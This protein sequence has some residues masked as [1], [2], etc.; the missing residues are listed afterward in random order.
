MHILL[1]ITKQHNLEAISTKCKI[2]LD[3]GDLSAL[4]FWPDAENL[5]KGLGVR[6]I[7]PLDLITNED[8]Y[9]L[10]NKVTDI[11]RNWWRYLFP[12]REEPKIEGL[13][14]SELYPYEIELSLSGILFKVIAIQKAIKRI[15][16]E[17]VLFISENGTG[18]NPIFQHIREPLGLLNFLYNYPISRLFKNNQEEYKNITLEDIKIDGNPVNKKQVRLDIVNRI[19]KLRKYIYYGEYNRLQKYFKRLLKKT[20]KF[21]DKVDNETIVISGGDRC[22]GGFIGEAAKTYKIRYLE[23]RLL[24]ICDVENHQNRENVFT[25]K[26]TLST[27]YYLGN[28][29]FQDVIES[30]GKFCLNQF[31]LLNNHYSHLKTS[32]I[33]KHPKAYITINAS[34]ALSRINIWAFHS[35]G[36]KTYWHG[37]GLGQYSNNVLWKVLESSNWMFF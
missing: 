14:I 34:D 23:S 18:A 28:I 6:T 32:I 33:D 26:A 25:E 3:T 22:L 16:P 36:V 37:D 9:H 15:R 10:A 1:I 31:E 7:T 24:S 4:I 29:S 8:H 17:K 19:A 20:G 5:F 2:S 30:I 13:R 12:N 27:K 21:L 35:C 11:S